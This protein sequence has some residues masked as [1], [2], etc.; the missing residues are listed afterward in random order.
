VNLRGKL[1]E[2]KRADKR[3]RK[4]AFS[5]VKVRLALDALKALPINENRYGRLST[6]SIHAIPDSMPQAHNP[7]GQALTFPTFQAAGF[8]MALNEIAIPIGFIALCSSTLL[9]M[10]ADKRKTFRVIA[11]AML[12]AV[13]GIV[14]TVDGRPWFKLD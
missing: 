5:P 14:V 6:F 4:Q 9:D 3:T 13:G 1:D 12:E 8:L 2:W 10:G 7:A 11:R